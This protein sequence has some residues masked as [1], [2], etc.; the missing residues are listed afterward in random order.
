VI[1]KAAQSNVVTCALIMKRKENSTITFPH[2][3]TFYE[4]NYGNFHSREARTNSGEE[5]E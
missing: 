2:S 1:A 3:A 5:V 4:V